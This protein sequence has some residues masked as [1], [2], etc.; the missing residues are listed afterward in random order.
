MVTRRRAT[1][2]GTKWLIFIK[3][4]ERP[5]SFFV[6]TDFTNLSLSEVTFWLL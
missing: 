4:D 6:G 2:K 5:E 3:A 1:Q